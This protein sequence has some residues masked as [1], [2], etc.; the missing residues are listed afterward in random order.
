MMTICEQSYSF[1]DHDGRKTGVFR[2]RKPCVSYTVNGHASPRERMHSMQEERCTLFCNHCRIPEHVVFCNHFPIPILATFSSLCQQN[3]IPRTK[4]EQSV[5]HAL[6]MYYSS[7][8]RG[9]LEVFHRSGFQ[10]LLLC[11]S[12]ILKQSMSA[13]AVARQKI[14]GSTTLSPTARAETNTTKVRNHKTSHRHP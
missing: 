8:I 9:F 10:K 7:H 2:I 12:R 3:L 13:V 14:S 11:R 5:R 4:A 6:M 1:R